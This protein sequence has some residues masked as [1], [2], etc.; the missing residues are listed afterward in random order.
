MVR[1]K[2]IAPAGVEQLGSSGQDST[3]PLEFR[4]YVN[5][6]TLTKLPRGLN[7]YRGNRGGLYIDIRQLIDQGYDQDDVDRLVGGEGGSPEDNV[8]QPN[9]PAGFVTAPRTST[10]VGVD[11]ED[12]YGTDN[13]EDE[14]FYPQNNEMDILPEEGDHYSALQHALYR[15]GVQLLEKYGIEV[16]FLTNKSS[17]SIDGKSLI[18]ENVVIGGIRH[19]GKISMIMC[20]DDRLTNGIA[21]KISSENTDDDGAKEDIDQA[22]EPKKRNREL[23]DK[24]RKIKQKPQ[25]EQF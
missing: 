20:I 6:E 15:M 24:E 10:F 5:N 2:K 19:P 17:K 3:V 12:M 4:R 25:Q 16:V 8:P 13:M 23:E 11:D 22:S 21:G 18:G 7:V 1:I 14:G 9:K